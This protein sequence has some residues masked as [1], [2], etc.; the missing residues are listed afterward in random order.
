[1]QE[2]RGA[3]HEPRTNREEQWGQETQAVPAALHYYHPVY[4]PLKDPPV[5]FPPLF[6]QYETDDAL[7]VAS[8]VSR[9]NA[10]L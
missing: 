6:L 4:D 2:T 5:R 9:T 3:Q 8:C 10:M 7:F 1:M